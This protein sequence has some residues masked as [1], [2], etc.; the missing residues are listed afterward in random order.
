MIGH[1]RATRLSVSVSALFLAAISIV[2]AARAGDYWEPKN[3]APV[4]DPAKKKQIHD[5]G[6]AIWREGNEVYEAGDYKKA[7]EIFQRSIVKYQILRLTD[8]IEIVKRAIKA[9]ACLDRR[10]STD[11]NQLKELIGEHEDKTSG[12]MTPYPN[13]CLPFPE[14]VAAVQKR[15]A[16]LQN[17]NR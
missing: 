10:K 6:A 17:T 7:I 14:L 8:D 5:D 15:I 16:A 1:S 11:I 4:T 12:S 13:S 3:Y 9:S 2:S